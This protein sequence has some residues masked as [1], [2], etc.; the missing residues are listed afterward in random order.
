MPLQQII[1]ENIV[2]K[3]EISHQMLS[4]VNVQIQIRLYCTY[5]LVYLDLHW[6]QI[7]CQGSRSEGVHS[8]FPQNLFYFPT[9]PYDVGTQK[10]RLTEM[11]PLSTHNI[12]LEG[13]RRILEHA[14]LPLSRALPCHRFAS[15]AIPIVLQGQV[16][17]LLESLS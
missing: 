16:I 13:Q 9:K 14:K 2:G 17:S 15:T 8:S 11:I 7:P 3:G 10:N 4:D 5:K 1:L 6:Y 12:G